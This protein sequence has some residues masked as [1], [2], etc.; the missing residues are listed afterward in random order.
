MNNRVLYLVYKKIPGKN[1][2]FIFVWWNEITEYL[3]IS[4]H[5]EITYYILND[6]EIIPSSV[7]FQWNRITNT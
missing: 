6:S 1:T 5:K 7:F 4:K 2:I 3:N